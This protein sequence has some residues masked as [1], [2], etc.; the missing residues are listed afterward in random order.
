M[1]SAQHVVKIGGLVLFR[2]L[3]MKIVIYD[4]NLIE[5]CIIFIRNVENFVI[6]NDCLKLFS[7]SLINRL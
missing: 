5:L 2:D 1:G 3:E 7:L 4:S 6:K